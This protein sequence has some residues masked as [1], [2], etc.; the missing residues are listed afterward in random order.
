MGP[1]K[2]PFFVQVRVGGLE[3]HPA[4]AVA[5]ASAAIVVV[6]VVVVVVA[7]V[8]VVVVVLLDV[9]VGPRGGVW[10]VK[11]LRGVFLVADFGGAAAR[12]QREPRV[13]SVAFAFDSAGR[14]E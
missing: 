11:L 10:L 8:V 3:M 14:S 9:A 1:F 6:V 13:P 2:S 4:V 5:A 7:V 12:R